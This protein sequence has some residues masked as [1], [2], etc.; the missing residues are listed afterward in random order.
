MRQAGSLDQPTQQLFSQ[1]LDVASQPE[2]RCLWRFAGMCEEA[3]L[4]THAAQVKQAVSAL[5]PAMQKHIFASFI[6]L[7]QNIGRYGAGPA[8]DSRSPPYGAL[9]IGLTGGGQGYIRAAN[10]IPAQARARLEAGLQELQRLDRA[11][12]SRRYR[13]QLCEP[14]VAGKP[15]GA[16]GLGLIELV[17]RSGPG[18]SF[19]FLPVNESC[20]LFTISL[21]FKTI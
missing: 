9:Q 13:E 6:E 11:G 14:C 12:L 2:D 21:K 16:A 8:A 7:F 3:R 19:S 10:L 1:A 15:N 18:M 20:Y 4:D 5:P 17:K